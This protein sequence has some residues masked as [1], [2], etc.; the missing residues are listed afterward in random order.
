VV[1]RFIVYS[2]WANVMTL[3]LSG[4]D[5]VV[6]KIK[7]FCSGERT[8]SLGIGLGDD[9]ALW[10][11]AA[12]QQ[13]VLTCDWFL[14]GT[15]FLRD[16][17]SPAAVG[18]KSLA[19]ATSDIAAMGGRPRC[20]L[21]SLALPANCTGKWLSG[22][23]GG[24]R[25]A[26][27]LLR[28]PLA[29]GD[30]TRHD[31]ILINISVIGEV[32]AG[33]AVLRSGA[34]AGDLLYVSGKLGEAEWGL[35]ELRRRHGRGRAS[36]ISLRKHLYPEPRIALGRWLARNRLVSA[37]MDLSDGLSSDLPRFCSASGV[38]ARIDVASLP[39]I[40]HINR[41]ESV[42]LALHGGDDYELL[43]AVPPKNACKI[44][45]KYHGVRLTRIGEIVRKKGV[46]LERDGRLLPLAA[47]GWDPFR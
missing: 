27:R 12:G 45:G 4:E 1:P 10:L 11:P 28:C 19:R 40:S 9:A 15:H 16:R 37:M 20:F 26:A 14:E 25:R 6:R 17:H 5:S 33:E 43:F 31:E 42:R 8:L 32:P 36:H 41:E 3:S 24:L 34:R 2:C 7:R 21:L 47:G 29:G 23:L 30:T 46:L 39:R 38:G 18:W 44:K 13:T 35:R 22:F